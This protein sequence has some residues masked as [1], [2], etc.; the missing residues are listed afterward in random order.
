MQEPSHYKAL[1]SIIFYEL[2]GQTQ[3]VGVPAPFPPYLSPFGSAMCCMFTLPINLLFAG[4]PFVNR[5]QMLL[6]FTEKNQRRV[7][8]GAEK[9]ER[10]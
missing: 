7:G 10:S 1:F 8:R 4:A 3:K 9:G 2:L 5:P 6:F